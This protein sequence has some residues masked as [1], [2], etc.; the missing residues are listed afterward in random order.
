VNPFRWWRRVGT[1]PE[2]GRAAGKGRWVVVDVESSGLD[3]NRDR[4]IAVGALAVID[5]AVQ[6]GDAFEVVLRQGV[7]SSG[8][9]IEVHGI[10]GQEQ[11]RGEEPARALQEFLAFAAGDPLV[12]WHSAF[13]ARMLDRAAREYLGGRFSPPWIDL[14]ALAPLAWPGRVAGGTALD[15]W[16][17]AFGVPIGQRHRAIVDC[18]ATA[19]LFAAFLPHA[20]RLGAA[21]A[22]AMASLSAS[23]RWLGRP[24]FP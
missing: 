9:N 8:A 11:A 4:L 7:P 19:Q 10:G 21:T 14:A 16:I 3:A 17:A 12:A 18:L 2:A 13:D 1:S 5:G 15:D 23:G 6:L 22:G 20:Q 24:G